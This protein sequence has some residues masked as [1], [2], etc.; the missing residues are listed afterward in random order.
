MKE[1]TVDYGQTKN[2][3][4]HYLFI[5]VSTDTYLTFVDP[6]GIASSITQ[7]SQICDQR[8]I[9]KVQDPDGHRCLFSQASKNVCEVTHI[10]PYSKGDLYIETLMRRRMQAAAAAGLTTASLITDIDDPRNALNINANIHNTLFRV[11]VPN[12]D[13]VA[14]LVTPNFAMETTDIPPSP[15]GLPSSPPHEEKIYRM[16]L[17][18]LRVQL[19]AS[20]FVSDIHN[21]TGIKPRLSNVTSASSDLKTSAPP[22]IVGTLGKSSLIAQVLNHTRLDMSAIEGKWEVFVSQVV[23]K[24]L[25]GVDTADVIIGSDKRGTIFALYDHSEQFDVPVTKHSNLFVAPSGCSH[26][27][28]TVKYRGLFLNEEQPALTNWAM[29][30]FTNGTGAPLTGSPFSHIFYTKLFDLLLRMKANYLWPAQWASAFNVDDPLNQFLADYYGIVMGT[31][32]EE[33]MMQSIP[34]EWNLFGTGPWDYTTNNQTIDQFWIGGAE[35]AKPFESLYTIGMRGNGDLLISAASAIQTLEDIVADQRGILQNVFNIT[36]VTFSPQMWCLYQEVK[37]Y[38]DE[39][40]RVP[41]DVTLLWTDDNWGNLRRYPLP[42]ERNRTGGA[43][44]Y[45]HH[46]IRVTPKT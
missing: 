39:G 19:A 4:D 31:S 29:E 36:D 33:P 25:P 37:G 9:Q 14:I 38:Y 6:N 28:P 3:L 13:S 1:E 42:L 17:Q 12:R 34:V 18:Y 45:Y 24:P 27:E 15:L 2:L 16:T 5:P 41:D 7:S 32:H 22:V 23:K 26:G 46:Y 35:R 30:K 8:F 21:V 43:G 20:N 10:V 11:P 44:V 40:L